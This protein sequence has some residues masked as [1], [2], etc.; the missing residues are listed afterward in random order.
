MSLA[1]HTGVS[2]GLGGWIL[3]LE[4]I[5]C[6]GRRSP[7][8]TAKQFK[9][10]RCSLP[11]VRS[12]QKGSCS[13]CFRI[14]EICG[15]GKWKILVAELGHS[16]PQITATSSM[17]YL[18]ENAYFFNLLSQCYLAQHCIVCHVS[19]LSTTEFLSIVW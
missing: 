12:P 15:Y 11:Q 4:N 8:S 7:R 16:Q 13:N 14:L 17:M 1:H 5:P 18:K 10:R 9:H 19:F 3:C 2:L 6:Q